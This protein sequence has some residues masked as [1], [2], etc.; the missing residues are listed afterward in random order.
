MI[1]NDPFVM[2][3]YEDR[4]PDHLIGIHVKEVKPDYFKKLEET[5]E[6]LQSEIGVLQNMVESLDYE[7]GEMKKMR[8]HEV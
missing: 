4:P 2:P 6:T 1:N 3:W 5:I 8:N 7:I